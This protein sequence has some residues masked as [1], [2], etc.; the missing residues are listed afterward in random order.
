M[1]SVNDNDGLVDKTTRQEIDG[2]VVY[3]DNIRDGTAEPFFK[4]WMSRKLEL[5]LK[6][7]DYFEWLENKISACFELIEIFRNPSHADHY[8]HVLFYL[9]LCFEPW[10]S[11]WWDWL[12]VAP[13]MWENF[14]MRLGF[15]VHVI[16]QILSDFLHSD[17]IRVHGKS[18]TSKDNSRQ[19][20]RRMN[21]HKTISWNFPYWCPK[22]GI[23]A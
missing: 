9:I 13:R 10:V 6:Q 20:L 15:S 18:G 21:N 22:N 5:E 7:G 3:V 14:Q 4:N 19:W 23:S 16:G 12:F 8:A 1:F 2:D 17:M 11:Y